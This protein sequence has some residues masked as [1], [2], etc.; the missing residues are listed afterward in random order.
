MIRTQVQLTE[1]QAERLKEQA[2]RM[3]VSVAELVRRAIDKSLE[4]TERDE[5]WRRASALVGRYRDS[6]EDLAERHDDYLDDVYSS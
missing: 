3:D 2:R 6:A 5:Q 1:D 4:E